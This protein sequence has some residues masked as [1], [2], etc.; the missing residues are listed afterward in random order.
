VPL[1]WSLAPLFAEGMTLVGLGYSNP[2]NIRV[3][4]GEIITLFVSNTKTVLP[5]GSPTLRATTL[6]LPTSLGGFSVNIR[7]S[8]TTNYPA[9]LFSVEQGLMCE[10]NRRSGWTAATRS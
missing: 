9:P 2:T 6:P 3:S 5:L 4:P 1:V 10:F 8:G 7:Q